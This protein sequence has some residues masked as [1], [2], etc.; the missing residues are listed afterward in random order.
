[1]ARPIIIAALALA[2]SNA[3][4]FARADSADSGTRVV[5]LH[6]GFA[7]DLVLVGAGLDSGFRQGML[8]FV[9]RDGDK[10]AA[11]VLAEVRRA[12]SAGLIV[13]TRSNKAI[14]LG[15]VVSVK[16]LKSQI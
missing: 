7:A 13:D 3:S 15:D 1:M 12:F 11:V 2:L 14:R 4:N 6:N 8:C 16:I 10:L 9:S 5:G